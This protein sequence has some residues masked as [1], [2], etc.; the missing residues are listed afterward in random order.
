MIHIVCPTQP[1]PYLLMH[2][3]TGDLGVRASGGMAL[4]PPKQ[5]YLVSSIRRVS[6]HSSDYKIGLRFYQSVHD[7]LCFQIFWSGNTI[8]KTEEILKNFVSVWALTVLS[9]LQYP[10]VY[11]WWWRCA[12]YLGRWHKWWTCSC[13]A[14]FV[15]APSLSCYWNRSW[16]V[17]GRKYQRL[18]ARL[19]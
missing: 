1:I 19:Q 5:D 9:Y 7:Y 12:R 14:V 15:T 6:R 4:S 10:F 11:S 3:C 18:R 16:Y 17:G 2:W 8:K 13:T